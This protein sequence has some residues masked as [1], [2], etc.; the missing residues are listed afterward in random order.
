MTT[1]APNLYHYEDLVALTNDR[2]SSEHLTLDDAAELRTNLR[3]ALQIPEGESLA[4]HL[5]L[6][7]SGSVFDP[8]GRNNREQSELA[9]R[10]AAVEGPD[11]HVA[12]TGFDGNKASGINL[13]ELKRAGYS[14]Y[15]NILRDLLG[16]LGG[17]GTPT[18]EALIFAREQVSA[19][20][21]N[22]IVVVTDGAS[23]EPEKTVATV[24]AA[25]QD[26]IRVIAV[27]VGVDERQQ[28]AS[29]DN[30]DCRDCFAV[31]SYGQVIAHLLNYLNPGSVADSELEAGADE[32]A[33]DKASSNGWQTD[34][35]KQAA[36]LAKLDAT[37]VELAGTIGT[38]EQRCFE[39]V[40]Q[41]L[42]QSNFSNRTL[43]LVSAFMKHL[44]ED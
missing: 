11:T 19:V 32:S 24:Q 40:R 16:L 36:L 44:G 42:A 26:G 41:E 5:L 38:C 10:F 8:A 4:L 2:F 31:D 9:L 33:A 27:I 17:G 21:N 13:F 3:V 12:V 7:R 35:A 23:A 20:D 14:G 22:V 25:R 6:D 1:I 37:L 43:K 18:N 39:L 29:F 34:P 30:F 15:P 28:Q